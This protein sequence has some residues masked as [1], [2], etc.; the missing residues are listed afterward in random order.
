[1][2][3]QVLQLLFIFVSSENRRRNLVALAKN[4]SSDKAVAVKELNHHNQTFILNFPH[5]KRHG[6]HAFTFPFKPRSEVLYRSEPKGNK[7]DFFSLHFSTNRRRHW[8]RQHCFVNEEASETFTTS[9][10]GHRIYICYQRIQ[11]YF[12]NPPDSYPC[13]QKYQGRGH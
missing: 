10:T 11:S 13:S 2:H 9:E 12:E 8:R 3:F 1:M 4:K 6:Q 7:I 5:I